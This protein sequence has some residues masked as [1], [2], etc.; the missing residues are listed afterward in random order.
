MSYEEFASAPWQEGY[1]YELI[2][3][4][5]V[6]AAL[7]R[8]SHDLLDDWLSEVLR[9]YKR[10]HPEIINY[11]S[12]APRIVIREVDLPTCPEPDIAAYRDLPLH[13][14]WDE[15]DW[16]DYSPILVVEIISEDNAW[17]DLDRNVDLYL[18]I[19]SIREYWIV[20][21][22]ESADR[23]S[24]IVYRRRGKNWQKPIY[25]AYQETY[26][27]KL[28]PGFALVMDPHQR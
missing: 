16:R 8:T 1:Q 7:P 17:K 14:P 20:D 11:V 13:L 15:L 25:V 28:L 21:P 27:T 4:T 12:T 2:H 6:V 10:S 5:I 24:M 23:P 3:G 19:P 26:T 9:S 18:Q 22:R